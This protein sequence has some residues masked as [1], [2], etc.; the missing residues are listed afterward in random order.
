[1]HHTTQNTAHIIKVVDI[2]AHACNRVFIVSIGYNAA[3]TTTPAAPPAMILSATEP[4]K[5]IHIFRCDHT[6]SG[7]VNGYLPQKTPK[8]SNGESFGSLLVLQVITSAVS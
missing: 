1:M 3:S 6:K 8:K 4:N 2:V 5:L 7:N